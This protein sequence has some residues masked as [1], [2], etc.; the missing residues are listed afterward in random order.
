MHKSIQLVTAK[1]V[2]SGTILEPNESVTEETV[3]V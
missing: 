2:K 3:Q 1:I